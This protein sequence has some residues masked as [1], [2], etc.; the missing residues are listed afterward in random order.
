MEIMT[1]R[2]PIRSQR[3]CW[4]SARICKRDG[5]RTSRSIQIKSKSSLY[6]KRDITI[7]SSMKISG[8]FT[9]EKCSGLFKS[10]QKWIGLCLQRTVENY[11][12]PDS[13]HIITEE[14]QA[15]VRRELKHPQTASRISQW[16]RRILKSNWCL[17]TKR[18]LLFKINWRGL[19]PC[20][21]IKR[22]RARII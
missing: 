5:G 7:L 13:N 2:Y 19:N 3:L 21:I 11:I 1:S 12:G 18:A 4:R 8:E 10:Y 14:K 17:V 15:R 16:L 22:R 9:F 20:K 6:P